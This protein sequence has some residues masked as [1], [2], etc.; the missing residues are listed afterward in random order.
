V[1]VSATSPG[2][3]D[4]AQRGVV[5][6]WTIAWFRR[7]ENPFSPNRDGRRDTVEATFELTR[8][9]DVRLRVFHGTT[10][11]AT[12][13][14]SS[15]GTGVHAYVW[16]G[17]D[18]DGHRVPNGSYSI[19]LE[20][21]TALGTRGRTRWARADVTRP[22]VRIVSAVAGRRTR[23]V[24]RVSEPVKLVVRYGSDKPVTEELPAGESVLTRSGA[25]RR[26]RVVAWDSA[27]NRS[28][29]VAARVRRV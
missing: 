29:V 12:L 9:A 22:T 27:E 11:I 25:V 4:S 23:L 10:R 26:V 16:N 7:G 14:S 15:L 6:D 17:R 13:V 19:R 8:T 28:D 20:A 2:Q 18:R 21:T 24:V 1:R 5:A 3:V